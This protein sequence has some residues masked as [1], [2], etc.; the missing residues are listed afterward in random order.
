VTAEYV[1]ELD[2]DTKEKHSDREREGGSEREQE[3][4]NLHDA[5]RGHVQAHVGW[6]RQQLR[7]RHD[8]RLYIYIYIYI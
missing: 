6:H 1:D 5:A 8:L 7:R 3:G 2:L 4:D